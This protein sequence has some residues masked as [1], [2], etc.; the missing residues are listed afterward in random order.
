MIVGVRKL[1]RLAGADR[2][3]LLEAAALLGLARAAIPVVRFRR[4]APLLGRHMAQTG[5]RLPPGA[6]EHV[7]RVGWS[8]EAAARRVPWESAC[9]TQAVAAKL[10]LRRRGIASTLY[11]GVRVPEG[12]ALDA[13]AW[14]RAGDTIVTGRDGMQRFSVVATFA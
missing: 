1:A 11:L 12:R 14:L 9:L 4:I 5:A 13:H 8:I 2:R 6:L 3:A 7:R 10:M